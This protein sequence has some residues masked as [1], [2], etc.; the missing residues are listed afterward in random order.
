MKLK[1][2][3]NSHASLLLAV[4]CLTGDWAR[5]EPDALKVLDIT[6][7]GNTT[8]PFINALKSGGSN[9]T[10][11]SPLGRKPDGFISLLGTWKLRLDRH[12]Q[13]TDEKYFSA[14]LS[15]EGW[16]NFPISGSYGQGTA[17]LETERRPMDWPEGFGK[18]QGQVAHSFRHQAW[19]P[20]VRR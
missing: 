12:D 7:E 14:E 2:M 13:G 20:I 10:V 19:T 17:W 3:P 8:K 16:W 6:S 5:S 15:D 9:V 18:N 1:T 11:S 4:V